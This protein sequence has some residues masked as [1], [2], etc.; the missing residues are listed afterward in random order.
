MIKPEPNPGQPRLPTP[1]GPPE[2]GPDQVPNPPRA[3]ERMRQQSTHAAPLV[4][5]SDESG[6]RTTYAGPVRTHAGQHADCQRCVPRTTGRS[7]PT[8]ALRS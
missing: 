2:P 5:Y 3:V 8:S 4:H 6:R 7:L 1:S